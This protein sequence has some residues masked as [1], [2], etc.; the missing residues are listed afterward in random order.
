MQQSRRTGG[1][2]RLAGTAYVQD[3]TLVAADV[4]KSGDGA[5]ISN[6][7]PVSDMANTAFRSYEFDC[8][9]DVSPTAINEW[10]GRF[11]LFGVNSTS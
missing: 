8:Q 11:G 7:G 3:C 9:P 6:V 1:A 5:A 4:L 2:E 10:W